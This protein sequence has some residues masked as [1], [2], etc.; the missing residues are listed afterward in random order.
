MAADFM[1]TCSS[2][3]STCTLINRIS[4]V[5]LW[6]S[7]LYSSL[8]IDYHVLILY[9]YVYMKNNVYV[10]GKMIHKFCYS[11]LIM[12]NTLYTC[13]VQVRVLYSVHCTVQ[14]V[15]LFLGSVKFYLGGLH[16]V[17]YRVYHYFL[18]GSILFGGLKPPKP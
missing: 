12:I 15:L 17:L 9:Q 14:S 3:R 16:T 8:H 11:H 13:T 2:V 7:V 18:L 4:V 10:I 6:V 5:S 1:D